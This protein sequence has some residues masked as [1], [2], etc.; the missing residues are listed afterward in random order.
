MNEK[1]QR[2]PDSEMNFQVSRTVTQLS[3]EC[4]KVTIRLSLRLSGMVW[5]AEY[6]GGGYP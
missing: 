2:M 3:G 5:H 4:A 6:D 1:S